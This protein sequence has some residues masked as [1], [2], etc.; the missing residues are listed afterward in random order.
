MSDNPIASVLHLNRHDVKALRLTDLYSLHRVVYSLFEDVRSDDDKSA[1]LPSGLLYYAEPPTNLQERRILMLANRPPAAQ[2]NG[3]YGQV[4]SKTVPPDF[5]GYDIYRFK[6]LI[7]PTRRNNASGKLTPVKGRTAIAEW[8]AQRAENGWGFRVDLEKLQI[9]NM[10]VQQFA[11]KNKHPV[12]L[13]RALVRGILTVTERDSFKQS[14]SQ[15][16]GRGRAFGCGLLQ[17]VPIKG[18][19]A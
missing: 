9:D 4:E 10:D 15:G 2:V 6:V 7:N 19:S 1:G 18:E 3:Q 17:I 13:G 11:D 8:F 14:F 12:T 16:I 5:L